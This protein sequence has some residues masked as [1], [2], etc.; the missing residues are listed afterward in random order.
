MAAAIF[1]AAKEGD[2]EALDALLARSP[3]DINEFNKKGETA[4][5]VAALNGR[6]L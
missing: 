3:A 4:L 2:L 6:V 1:K 5:L